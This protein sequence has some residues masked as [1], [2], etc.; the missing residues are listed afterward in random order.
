MEGTMLHR[1]NDDFPDEHSVEIKTFE[2]L[3]DTKNITFMIGSSQN[4]D[5][6][7]SAYRACKKAGKIF[8]I[9]IYTAWI[10]EK[11]SAISTATP[12]IEWSDVM[13]LKNFGGNYYEKIKS[14]EEYFGNFKFKLFKHT[15]SLEKIKENSSQFYVK[16]SPWHIEKLLKATDLIFA[17][18]IYSQ[19]LG[20]LTPEFSDEKTVL[21]YKKLQED[22]NWIYAHTSGHAD[23]ESLQQ[24]ASSLQPKVLIPIHTEHKNEFHAYFENTHILEDGIPFD[25]Q[26]KKL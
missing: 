17:N 1:S 8:I 18:I 20:Y 19:W 14:H 23:L 15:I 25:V 4:I 7:I 2:T 11:I 6:I 22:Y 24:F 21:L 13:V 5:S 3:K 10:L 26:S 12:K 16:I 9:D